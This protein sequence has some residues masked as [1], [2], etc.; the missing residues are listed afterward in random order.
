VETIALIIKIKLYAALGVKMDIVFLLPLQGILISV[1]A[2]CSQNV[3]KQI[4]I[5]KLVIEDWIRVIGT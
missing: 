1:P 4:K 3:S 2:N 5:K